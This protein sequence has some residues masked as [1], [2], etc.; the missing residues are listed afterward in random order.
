MKKI[1]KITGV[2]LAIFIILFIVLAIWGTNDSK[3]EEELAKSN[4]NN[5]IS[6]EGDFSDLDTSKDWTGKHIVVSGKIDNVESLHCTL[7][8]NDFVI[9][10]YCDNISENIVKDG[11]VTIDG[12]CTYQNSNKIR[13]RSCKIINFIEPNNSVEQEITEPITNI[14]TESQDEKTSKTTQDDKKKTEVE[15]TEPKQTVANIDSEWYKKFFLFENSEKQNKLEL[16]WYDDAG[17]DIAINDTSIYYFNSQRYE[18][19]ADGNALYTCDDGTEFLYY[20]NNNSVEIKS[21]EYKGLYLFTDDTSSTD[22]TIIND[23]FSYAENIALNYTVNSKTLY[24]AINN[25]HYDNYDVS[26]KVVLV[27]NAAVNNIS[28]TFWFKNEKGFSSSAIVMFHVSGGEA[29][30]YAISEGSSTWTDNLNERI[31]KLIDKLTN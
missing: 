29:I 14:T 22:N 7:I 11:I 19:T 16:I 4:I 6:F 18:I 1:F 12:V 5:E 10:A 24:N 13:M 21:G 2:I 31:E 27:D 26:D 15:T 8:N 9:K 23:D 25:G 17:I 20:P 3:K 30:P 28:V